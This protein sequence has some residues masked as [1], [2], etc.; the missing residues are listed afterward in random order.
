VKGYRGT[1]KNNVVVLDEGIRLP[2]GTS[3]EVRVRRKRGSREEK[4]LRIL[5]NPITDLVGMDEIIE[6]DKQEREERWDFGGRA[7]P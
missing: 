6:Q 1:V 3:V 4:F 5:D 2:E 7:Q